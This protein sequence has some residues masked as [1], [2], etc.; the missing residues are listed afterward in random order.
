[1]PS[2]AQWSAGGV[3]SGAG[4]RAL[5]RHPRRQVPQSAASAIRGASLHGMGI[6]LPAGQR[7]ARPGGG[8]VEVAFGNG[9][10][11][12]AGPLVIMPT[13]READNIGRALQR[14]RHC[15][16]ASTVLVVD[17]EGHDG[18]ADLAEVEGR[19][20]GGVTVMRRPRKGGLAGAYRAGFSWGL[21]A[22]YDVLVGMDADLSHDATALPRLLAVISEG[23]D[24]VVGS[25]YVPGG[26]T[27]DWPL[28]RRVLSRWGNWYAKRALGSSVADLTSAFRAY[29]SDALRQVDL[30]SLRAE[31]YGFLM[32]LAYRLEQA[33]A[34]FAEVPVQFINRAEGR[35]KMSPR[36][37]AE[38][39]RVVSAL[40]LSERVRRHRSS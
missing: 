36:I 39:L 6:L 21:D 30:G 32:E 2:W 8:K 35:S 27:V 18:T 33:G 5:V 10:R 25:R 11:P 23:V 22:G 9:G 38:S 15:L 7:Q 12:A 28:G 34:K 40:A 24:V 3:P 14:V 31:G 4:R 19:R 16:P 1:M 37:A 13:Y 20:L 17:D 26:S 29:R